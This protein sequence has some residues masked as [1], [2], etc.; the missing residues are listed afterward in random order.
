MSRGRLRAFSAVRR[1]LATE[2][3]GMEVGYWKARKRPRRARGRRLA[4]AVGTHDRV[5][6]ALPD[7]QV[8]AVEDL[9]GGIRGRC[10]VQVA[11]DEGAVVVH[12]DAGSPGHRRAPFGA[13]TT[14]SPLL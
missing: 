6:L 5:H 14:G 10:D 11:D 13:P 8:D 12:G 7:G 3:P 4:R 9:V 2:R 1:K